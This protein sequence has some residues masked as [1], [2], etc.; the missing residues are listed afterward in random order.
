[1]TP[2]GGINSVAAIPIAKPRIRT[3]FQQHPAHLGMSLPSSD[4]ERGVARGI[5]RID[6]RTPIQE[7]TH[8][9]RIASRSRRNEGG[10]AR[11]V[12]RIRR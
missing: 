7:C 1:M 11:K 2:R 6:H 12:F 5:L 8:D 9:D 4:D 10:V 3:G